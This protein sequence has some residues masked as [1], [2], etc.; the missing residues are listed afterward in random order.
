MHPENDSAPSRLRLRDIQIHQ[1]S[2]FAA[3]VQPSTSIR[4]SVRPILAYR[5]G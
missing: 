5:V 2:G 4:R 3:P 1:E